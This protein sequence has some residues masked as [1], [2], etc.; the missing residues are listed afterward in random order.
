MNATPTPPTTPGPADPAGP[1]RTATGRRM[2]IA[3]V[4]AVA[5]VVVAITLLGWRSSLPDPLATH[6]DLGGTPDGSTGRDLFCW[7][8]LNV[9]VLVAGVGLVA[10]WR[11]HGR[12]VVAGWAGL[13]SFLAWLCAG[14]VVWTVVI[15]RGVTDWRQVDGPMWP[16]L[17][18]MIVAASAAAALSTRLA[19]GLAGVVPADTTDGRLGL[20]PDE[21]A[22]WTHRQRAAWPLVLSAAGAVLVAV[23]VL[24]ATVVIGVVGGI[25]MVVGVEMSSMRVTVDRRGLSVGWGPFCLPTTRIALDRVG[26][27]TGTDIRPM[28]WGGWG[29]RGSLRLM[30]KAAAV[31]RAGEGIRVD[32]RDGRQFA[33]TVDDATTGARLLNDLAA[34][35][36]AEH[37]TPAAD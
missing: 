33:V 14:I 36:G 12:T 10:A 27:A 15:H 19:L 29:Y 31:L 28:S 4:P 16:G 11:G 21:L 24:T 34:R 3:A 20:G 1:R 18:T 13:S 5:V 37:S 32:L 2:A 30:G 7:I 35:H 22:T 23:G 25:L 26:R 9:V 8:T 6:F 17:A